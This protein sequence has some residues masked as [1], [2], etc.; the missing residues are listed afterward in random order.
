MRA[1]ARK[2]RNGDPT[3]L[4]SHGAAN[5]PP[6]SFTDRQLDQVLAGAAPL[7]VSNH[8]ALH[9]VVRLLRR[10]RMPVAVKKSIRSLCLAAAFVAAAWPAHAA[11]APEPVR[12]LVEIRE[13][14]GEM[15]GNS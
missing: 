15:C 5:M 4:R 14:A 13:R 8:A 10:D 11:S 6:T 9:H 2:R 12:D 7:H 3:L 1:G